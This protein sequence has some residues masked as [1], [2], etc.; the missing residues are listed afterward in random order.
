MMQSLP[1]QFI[2]CRGAR[3]AG[4]ATRVS[5]QRWSPMHK[6]SLQ[7]TSI[8]ASFCRVCLGKINQQSTIWRYCNDAIIVEMT[9]EAWHSLGER[10]E[11]FW[12]P[13]EPPVASARWWSWKG[14]CV[15]RDISLIMSLL[16]WGCIWCMKSLFMLPLCE[17]QTLLLF[18]GGGCLIWSTVC[19]MN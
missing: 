15:G 16:T 13:S 11:I 18:F 6:V 8:S 3:T 1:L 5:W 2:A 19:A 7:Q 4:E 10:S 14:V 9:D 17:R 12:L